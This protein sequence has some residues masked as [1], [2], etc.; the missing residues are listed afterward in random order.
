[1]TKIPPYEPKEFN[2]WAKDSIEALIATGEETR[3][4]LKDIKESIKGMKEAFSEVE[5]TEGTNGNII[6]VTMNRKEFDNI[7]NAKPTTGEV[8]QI[9]NNQVTERFKN[10]RSSLVK[11]LSLLGILAGIVYGII[12]LA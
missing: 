7:Q 6:N 4:C 5:V 3:S 2:E 1:M 12:G 9:T 11:Y 10:I 8:K